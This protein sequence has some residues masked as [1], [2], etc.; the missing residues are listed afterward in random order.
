[1]AREADQGNRSWAERAHDLFPAGSNGEYDL[2][3]DLVS[4]FARANGCRVWDSEGREYLDYTM[5]WGS[6]LV[7]HA[8]PRIADAVARSARNASNYAALS[9]PLVELAERVAALNP[10][11]ERLR[12]VTSG[13]EATLTCV[14]IARGATGR[15]KLLKFDGAFHGS[16]VEGVANFGWS[17]AGNL[18]SAE[19]AGTGGAGAVG[20]LLVAPYN[21]LPASEA[22]IAAHGSE[23]AAVIIDP[24]Q[25][26]LVAEADFV[27]GLRALTARHG[28]LLIFDEVVS[29]F[30]IAPGGAAEYFG[31]T[32]DLAAY[33][34]ALGG[35]Y[36]IAAVAGSA[37]VMDE[38]REDRHDG[39]RFV[40]AASTTGGGPVMAAAALATL[41]VLSEAGTYARLHELGH[42]LRRGIKSVFAELGE[43]VQVVGD[44]PIAQYHL[45]D[46][47]IVDV[48]SETTAD[49][50]ARRLI[51]LEL[52]RHGV[53]VNPMLTKI[54]LSLAHD[55]AAIDRFVD[56]LG[57]AASQVR[58]STT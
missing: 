10:W 23:L 53:F 28:A 24:L 7:G 52:V 47:P 34:K 32:P 40:W 58:T 21:D 54:Y 37:A 39:P 22:L 41:D 49:Q 35:G 33:G 17:D 18:P 20:D 51:D 29:G 9:T 36:P 57:S 11:I 27:R 30:R 4:V 25:R 5:A 2:P 48:G 16:H 3:P 26:A 38:V 6:A 44:G 15:P 13:S 8:H 42:R 55:E 56:E 46:R 50:A 31:V 1:M 14:R 12:F 43:P 45:T 19:I